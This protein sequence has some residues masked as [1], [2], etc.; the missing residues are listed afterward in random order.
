MILLDPCNGVNPSLGVWKRFA[1]HFLP[2]KAVW[3]LKVI[4]FSSFHFPYFFCV[5]PVSSCNEVINVDSFSSRMFSLALRCN[6]FFFL[7]FLFD[8]FNIDQFLVDH[9]IFL[10]MSDLHFEWY[11]CLHFFSFCS[12]SFCV[13]RRN[14]MFI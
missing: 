14:N 5:L 8:F 3:V 4:L 9:H 12:N 7:L 2:S 10:L 6:L 1:T 13:T 11:L